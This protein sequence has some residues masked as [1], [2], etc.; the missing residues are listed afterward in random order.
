MTL[1]D[2]NH[3]VSNRVFKLVRLTLSL[4][5]IAGSSVQ[6]SF[7]GG[8][9]STF[10]ISRQSV[11][12]PL[13]VIKHTLLR[14]SPSCN[15]CIA[16]PEIAGLPADK[17][18]AMNESIRQLV[19]SH[20]SGQTWPAPSIDEAP[21]TVEGTY[22]IRSLGPRFISVGF[23]FNNYFGDADGVIE[24][25][26]FN[27]DLD[28][29]RE[30]SLQD[31]TGGP[32]DY[33]LISDLCRIKL[34]QTLSSGEESMILEGSEP[35]ADNFCCWF[36]N[37]KGITVKFSQYQVAP[38]AVGM[39]EVNISYEELKSVIL[40]SSPAAAA[41]A[42][43]VLPPVSSKLADPG[44]RKNQMEIALECFVARKPDCE[45]STAR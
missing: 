13:A 24:N 8:T 23:Y 17:A 41:K 27:Y 32:V 2:R 36:L 20:I 38:H 1:S 6:P 28:T 39:P 15:I 18:A 21:W 43:A 35:R 9:D 45:M 4:C 5:M 34:F 11:A 19:E 3:S 33:N 31:F 12:H 37:D 25:V 10:S 22:E 26:S 30:L 29:Q 16:Y 40:I 7:A 44:Y 42:C 14:K